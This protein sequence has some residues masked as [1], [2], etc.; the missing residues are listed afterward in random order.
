M[1]VDLGHLSIVLH[2]YIRVHCLFVYVYLLQCLQ[3]MSCD[4]NL[5]FPSLSTSLPADHPD[6]NLRDPYSHGSLVVGNSQ[7]VTQT[8]TGSLTEPW[9]S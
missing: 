4:D 2:V 3:T 5:T 8:H 9:E 6:P 1:H 7:K